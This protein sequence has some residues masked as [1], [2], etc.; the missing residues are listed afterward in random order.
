MWTSSMGERDLVL[1]CLGRSVAIYTGCG[2]CDVCDFIVP[3]VSSLTRGLEPFLN[4][5]LKRWVDLLTLQ[6]GGTSGA[7][8]AET[9]HVV[10]GRALLAPCMLPLIRQYL[11]NIWIKC[12]RNTSCVLTNVLA[13]LW[14]GRQFLQFTYSFCSPLS[15]S[16]HVVEV[17]ALLTRC[18]LSLIRQY[19]DNIGIKCNQPSSCVLRNVLAV[20]WCDR[21]FLEV[22]HSFFFP[23]ETWVFFFC[24][25]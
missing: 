8:L 4:V 2:F 17:R 25:L 15:K 16:E 3:S 23:L 22:I 10:E 5:T 13:V 21:Q 7:R 11:D 19:L 24:N 20:L 1:Q 9:S 12:N 14:C 18:M 6:R